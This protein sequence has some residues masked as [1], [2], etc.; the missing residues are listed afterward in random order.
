MHIFFIAHYF[1]YVMG[2][3]Y[4]IMNELLF[5]QEKF[6]LVRMWWDV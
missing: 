6:G 2:D 5:E 1:G 3:N 4:F